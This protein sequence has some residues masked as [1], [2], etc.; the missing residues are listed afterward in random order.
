MKPAG[1]FLLQV[2]PSAIGIHRRACVRQVYEAEKELEGD[3]KTVE[4][5]ISKFQLESK[6]WVSI[7]HSLATELKPLG[8]VTNWLEHT[9]G[10]LIQ[11]AEDINQLLSS[12]DSDVATDT[13][14]SS[15]G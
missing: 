5:E 9:E 11:C 13:S 15:P 3:L 8:D 1:R 14:D 2:F 10:S 12:D 6:Q 4:S 7:V